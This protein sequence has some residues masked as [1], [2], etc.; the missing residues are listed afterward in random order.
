MTATSSDIARRC[1][2]F[3]DALVQRHPDWW[4]TLQASGRLEDDHGPQTSDLST[5][6]GTFGLDAGLRVFRNRE[7]LR[8][9]WRELHR[10]APVE[11]TLADLTMLAE[12]CLQAAL[13][14]HHQALVER[15]GTPRDPDGAAQ[16]AV[17]IGMGKLGGRELNLSSDIDLVF[18]YPSGGE[19]DGPRATANEQFFTRLTRAVVRSLSEVTEHGFCFRVDTRLRPFGESG[20]L[21]C[22]F[23]AMEQYY[24][25]EGR[26]WERYAL[27]KARPVAGDLAAGQELLSLL[28]PFVYRRYIDFGAIEALQDMHALV[29]KDAADRG[30]EED[31]KRGPGGIRE[32]EFIVQAHQLLRGGR[33][34]RLQTTSLF[35]ALAA[36]EE[37]ALLD[38]ATAS[39]LRA[40]YGYLRRL[41]NAIQALHDQ[42]THL[43]PSG[44][45]L[46]RVAE[47]M[48]FATVDELR[49]ETGRVRAAV[50]RLFAQHLQPADAGEDEEP[51]QARWARLVGMEDEA[52]AVVEPSL[53][54]FME[55]LSRQSLS[56]R[57]SQRLDRFMPLLLQRLDQLALPDAVLQDVLELVLAVGRRSAYLSL[58]VQNPAALDRMLTL[59]AESAWVAT[60]VIRHPALLDEL[61]DPTLGSMLPSGM[62]TEER[63]RRIMHSHD[64]PEAVLQALNHLK[65]TTALRVAVAELEATLGVRQAQSTLTGLAEVLLGACLQLAT[66]EIRPRFPGAPENGLCIVGYGSLGAREL[67]Y[68]SDLDLIFLYHAPEPGAGP[69][70]PDLERFYT[71][72]VRRLLSLLT[73]PTASGRLYETDTRLRPNGRAGL[74]VSSLRA[75]SRYQSEQAWVWELQ[76]LSRARAIC[77][78]PE[79]AR[80]FEI[81]RRLVLEQHRN[82]QELRMEITRMRSR[83]RKEFIHGDRYKHGEGGLVDID[84]IAQM[85][86][87]EH[88]CNA[89]L[90][91][92]PTGTP[93]QLRALAEAGWLPRDQAEV[94]CK[95]HDALCAARHLTA[96]ARQGRT[97]MPDT[98]ISRQV[99]TE[100]LGS[101]ADWWFSPDSGAEDH[102]HGTSGQPH[103]G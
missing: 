19:C 11:S 47:A 43:L 100:V 63:V 61:I 8:I 74:L 93:A 53:R 95:T 54:R 48:G 33:E 34:P 72:V 6:I 77:G 88:A 51:W 96:I 66:A 23:G 22:S 84:F 14:A 59:F 31:I 78:N 89:P 18:C 81:T 76:A 44:Q 57:A 12:L 55:R 50:S 86:V 64:D 28:S 29:R 20:P 79:V 42:Q 5:V 21:V 46:V 1:S 52:L 2:P 85:G 67:A 69:A 80:E 30:R 38:C 98:S 40:H 68:G 25:R 103:S 101:L 83:M 32:I 56:Q 94:L 62:E 58:L 10:K 99:C 82:S 90:L 13:L 92:D 24:Q 87:L 39:E 9:V 70:N 4:E 37:L 45:D 41:E 35:G 7:M 60:S 97:R 75:F 26:D 71:Q 102:S 27:V 15:Y 65:L 73:L 3:L 49:A 16:A 36:L 91:L 17:V